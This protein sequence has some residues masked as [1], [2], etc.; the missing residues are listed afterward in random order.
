MKQDKQSI[1]KMTDASYVV[2]QAYVDTPWGFTF[3][4]V[5][6][7]EELLTTL[8]AILPRSAPVT[9]ELDILDYSWLIDQLK[10]RYSILVSRRKEM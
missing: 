8:C 2:Y 6:T 7:E 1:V 4:S 9:I 5:D 10:R 3:L